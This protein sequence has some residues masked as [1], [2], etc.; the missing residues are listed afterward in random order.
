MNDGPIIITLLGTC[1][2][3]SINGIYLLIPLL[4]AILI[5]GFII[6]SYCSM[7]MWFMNLP[8]KENCVSMSGYTW[9][10]KVGDTELWGDRRS[11]KSWITPKGLS[12]NW[13]KG[14]R[15]E[16]ASSNSKMLGP[17][18][19]KSKAPSMGNW[20][21]ESKILFRRWELCLNRDI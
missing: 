11:L 14:R 2:S 18:S 21:G 5:A 12:T 7:L 10:R 15:R 1:F 20:L 13:I 16:C 6:I 17:I 19:S 8:T 4:Y 3:I 9:L